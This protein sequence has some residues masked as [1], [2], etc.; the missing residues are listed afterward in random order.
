[1]CVNSLNPP[2]EIHF[3][4]LDNREIYLCF[5]DMMH[6]LCFIFYKMLFIL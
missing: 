6:S 1:M 3:I 4:Y 5:L 2:L